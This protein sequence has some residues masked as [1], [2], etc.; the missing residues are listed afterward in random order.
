ML[1]IF[2]F[3]QIKGLPEA[4]ETP[5]VC[6]NFHPDYVT[7]TFPAVEAFKEGNAVFTFPNT[8][9]KCAGAPQKIMYLTDSNFRQMGKRDKA[10]FEYHTSLPV[11]FGVKKYAD[12]LW[13]VIKERDINVNLRSNLIEVKPDSREAVFQNLDKPEELTTIKY[14]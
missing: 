14:K 2:D 12:S 11:L 3:V 6:S 8:P 10:K 9:I 13:E 7:K 4:F 1:A 5:G